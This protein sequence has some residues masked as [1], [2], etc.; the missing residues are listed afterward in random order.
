MNKHTPTEIKL[1]Q[2]SRQVEVSF[3]DDKPAEPLRLP[4][5]AAATERNRR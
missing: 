2:K 3:A 5:K 4:Q 1:Q